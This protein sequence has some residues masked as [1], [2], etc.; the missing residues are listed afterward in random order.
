MFKMPKKTTT[1]VAMAPPC[2]KL[3]QRSPK[4]TLMGAYSV[5]TDKKHWMSKEEFN[6][7]K[8]SLPLLSL[9]QFAI[10]FTVGECGAH[11]NK[12]KQRTK[13]NTVLVLMFYPKYSSNK[14]SPNC[15]NYCRRAFLKY[16]PWTGKDPRSL[17]GGEEAT[18]ADSRCMGT[19]FAEI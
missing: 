12:I 14:L 19:S 9:R 13:Q 7:G 18:D 8:E 5:C 2:N 17:W 3:P 11:R 10:P 16:V 1:T 4:L 6:V 15:T